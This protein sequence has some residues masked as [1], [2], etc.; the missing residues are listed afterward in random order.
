MDSDNTSEGQGDSSSDKD[1]SSSDQGGA[2]GEKEDQNSTESAKGRLSG[3]SSAADMVKQILTAS[4]ADMQNTDLGDLVRGALDEISDDSTDDNA[5]TLSTEKRAEP[6]GCMDISTV[7]KTTASLRGR[8]AGLIQSARYQPC[9][10]GKSGNRIASNA[11]SRLATMDQRVFK[12]SDNKQVIN[13]AVVVL[14]DRSSSMR[15][16]EMKIASQ[17]TLAATM[18]LD[19]IPGVSVASAAFPGTTDCEVCVMTN[20]GESVRSTTKFYS[21]T[22]SG[23]TPTNEA[24]DWA[25]IKLSIQPEPRKICLV[26]TDGQPNN[27]HSAQCAAERM[28]QSGIE[29][30]GIGIR[31]NEIKHFIPNSQIINSVSDLPQALFGVLQKQLTS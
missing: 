20:F 14:L 22:A 21:V 31:C 18:A 5:I 9:Y 16:S 6:C 8:L 25:G 30:L 24:L 12:R 27:S 3:G 7:R 29:V 15:G 23:Y 26:I 13:T 10:T 1:D 19:T 2:S 28:R 4:E 11:L 17:A